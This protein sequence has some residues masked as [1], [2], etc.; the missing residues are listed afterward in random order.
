MATL[1]KTLAAFGFIITTFSASASADTYHHIDELALT[2]DRQAKLLVSESVHYRHTPEYRHLV[3]DARDLCRL[4]THLHEV[5][6]HHGSLAHLESDLSQLDAKFHHL[7]SVFHRVERAA[8]YGHG[9]V[10]GHTSHVWELL[11]SIENN[12]HHLQDDLRSLRVPVH[13]VQPIVVRRPVVYAAPR[14]YHSGGHGAHLQR[15]N[16]GH[17]SHHY[18]RNTRGRGISFGGGSSRFTIR[19]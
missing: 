18:G 14:V 4:A 11:H 6:H 12:I 16:V 3:S 10:H 7:E 13:T 2:I 5:A 8:S 15:R 19:F 17:S 1:T 9:H